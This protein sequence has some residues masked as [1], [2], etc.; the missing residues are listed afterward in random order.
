MSLIE[1]EKSAPPGT[2]RSTGYLRWS[3]WA[4]LGALTFV[5]TQMQHPEI[6]NAA[7][8]RLARHVVQ[9]TGEVTATIVA[10]LKEEGS[11][12]YPD[13]ITDPPRRQNG[14]CSISLLASRWAPLRAAYVGKRALSVQLLHIALQERPE[15]STRSGRS[16]RA[17]FAGA[18]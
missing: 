7:I 8:E 16:A 11:Y 12:P 17:D 14:R 5:S 15:S 4:E 13:V 10:T 9:R 3:G 18:A 6:V 2:V 1:I